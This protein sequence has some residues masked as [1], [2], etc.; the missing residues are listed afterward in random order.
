MESVQIT[1]N[2]KS[3]NIINIESKYWEMHEQVNTGWSKQKRR[4]MLFH[5]NS[6]SATF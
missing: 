1:G 2:K 6:F 3:Q 5:I 4:S